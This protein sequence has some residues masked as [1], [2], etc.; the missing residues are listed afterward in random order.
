ME[1]VEALQPNLNQIQL[2]DSA[3]QSI[4]DTCHHTS[5]MV[6]SLL[7]NPYTPIRPNNLDRVAVTLAII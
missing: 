6:E 2:M 7:N 3:F 4:A 1:I 5:M